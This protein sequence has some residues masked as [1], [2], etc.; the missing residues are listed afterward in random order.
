[1]TKPRVSA[2]DPSLPDLDGAETSKRVKIGQIIDNVWRLAEAATLAAR[3]V[4]VLAEDQALTDDEAAGLV[5]LLLILTTE[6]HA[7][8]EAH[9]GE[10][11]GMRSLLS[12]RIE[13]G[14]A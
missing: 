4:R 2:A 3:G 11:S 14:R 7:L 9:S 5:E 8:R 6:V 1:M 10:K 12:N 13:E